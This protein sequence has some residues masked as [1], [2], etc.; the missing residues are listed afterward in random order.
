MRLGDRILAK[1]KAD[2]LSQTALARKLEISFSYLSRIEKGEKA[3][4][5]VCTPALARFLGITVDELIQLIKEEYY[6]GGST[7]KKRKL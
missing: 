3:P 2:G 4:G 5:L 6:E 1:R 7:F